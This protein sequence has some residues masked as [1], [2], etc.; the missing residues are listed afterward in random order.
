MYPTNDTSTDTLLVKL[1]SQRNEQAFQKIFEKYRDDIYTYAK[2]LLHSEEA[3][4]EVVQE[5]FMRIWLKAE[6]LDPDLNFKSFLF[7]MCRNLCFDSLRKLANSRK[8]SQELLHT[9]D[10]Y[11]DSV[12]ETMLSEDYQQLRQQAIDKLPPKRKL[13]FQMSRDREMT[14]EEISKELGI[15]ISTVKSQMTKAIEHMRTH[16]KKRLI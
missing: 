6:E 13:I 4:Q 15:T 10:T 2:A 9:S 16:V 14:Y 5:V 3:A 8:L 11:H 7:T 12:Q 1:L